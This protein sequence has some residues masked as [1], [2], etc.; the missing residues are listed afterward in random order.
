MASTGGARE[1]LDEVAAA[2][3]GI[4]EGRMERLVDLLWEVWRAGR[5]VF[6]CGNGGSACTASHMALDLAMHTRVAGQKPLRTLALTDSVGTLTAL[7]NDVGFDSVFAG[8]LH[9]FAQ[10]GDLLIC[11]SCSGNS[12]NVAR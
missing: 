6:L 11:I 9:G 3:D 7:A 4:D 5:T 1:H 10:A 8:Q 2:L 12:R